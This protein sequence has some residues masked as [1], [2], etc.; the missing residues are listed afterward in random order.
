MAAKWR[1]PKRKIK[2]KRERKFLPVIVTEQ[3]EHPKRGPASDYTVEMSERIVEWIANGRPLREFCRLP[4]TP[5]WITVYKW[6]EKDEDFRIRFAYAR[7]LGAD[8]IA[9]EAMDIADTP[10]IGVRTEEDVRGFKEITEDMLGHRRLRV[11]TR[12][13]LLAKWFPQKYGERSVQ[14][15]QTLDKDGNPITP[16]PVYIIDKR[17]AEKINEDLEDK[18]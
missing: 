17:E 7:S 9:E 14:Q 6:L 2:A 3:A 16:G 4:D 18:V 13:K 12:L 15:T 10:Q 1:K 8:A 5:A 11:E